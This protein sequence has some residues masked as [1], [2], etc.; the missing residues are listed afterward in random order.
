MVCASTFHFDR[1][2]HTYTYLPTSVMVLVVLV[3]SS[4]SMLSWSGWKL[5]EWSTVH[6]VCS[7]TEG[8]ARAWCGKSKR[9]NKDYTIIFNFCSISISSVI[10]WWLTIL[11]DLIL[12]LTLMNSFNKLI[13]I[14]NGQCLVVTISC[15]IK[16]A[17]IIV[18]C[19]SMHII[20]CMASIINFVFSSIKDLL[21]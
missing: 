17:A 3:H 2:M 11:M 19:G 15:S 7:H 8:G 10:M 6:Q 14:M 18:I 5:R 20:I 1:H 21:N 4:A 9:V 13:I 16:L 12:M